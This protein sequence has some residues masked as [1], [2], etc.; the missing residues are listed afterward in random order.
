MPATPGSERP[1]SRSTPKGNAKQT[2]PASRYVP[3][4]QSEAIVFRIAVV[5]FWKSPKTMEET[6]VP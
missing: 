3:T 5:S 4:G 2:A 1:K 6:G